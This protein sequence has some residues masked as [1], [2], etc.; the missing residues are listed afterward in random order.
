MLSRV[1]GSSAH[2]R[3]RETLLINYVV[4]LPS[5]GISLCRQCSCWVKAVFIYLLFMHHL[6][7]KR[8]CDSWKKMCVGWMYVGGPLT[9][10]IWHGTF[11]E[12]ILIG[13]VWSL[14]FLHTFLSLIKFPALLHHRFPSPKSSSNFLLYRFRSSFYLFIFNFNFIFQSQWTFNITVY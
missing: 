9:W 5:M 7:P 1:A 13:E 6:F 4:V 11:E 8:I 10:D 12:K 2:H 14:L 3:S